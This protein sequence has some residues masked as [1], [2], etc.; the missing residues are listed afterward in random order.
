MKG[1]RFIVDGDC[2]KTDVV[3]DLK[4]DAELCENF[5]DRILAR[6]ASESRRNLLTS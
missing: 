3:I 6:N 5:F 4:A 2:Q 1:V